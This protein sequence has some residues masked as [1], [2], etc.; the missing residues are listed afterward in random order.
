MKRCAD[1]GRRSN[2]LRT[3]GTGNLLIYLCPPER[4]VKCQ[5]R[6]DKKFAVKG[7]KRPHSTKVLSRRFHA[8]RGK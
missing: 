2:T 8:S 6:R 5:R 3:Y 4:I 7:K 1:C